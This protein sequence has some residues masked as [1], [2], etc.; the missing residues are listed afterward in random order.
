ME[1][2]EQVNRRKVEKDDNELPAALNKQIVLNT[3]FVRDDFWR[4]IGYNSRCGDDGFPVPGELIKETRL[5]MQSSQK[6]LASLIGCDRSMVAKME[7][8]NHGLDSLTPRRQ[9]AKALGI[10]PLAFGLVERKDVEKQ[11][12][13]DPS[14]LRKAL[15]L[16][17]EVYFS[18]G[19]VGG[20]AEVD[21]MTAK[22]Y[23]ISKG[24]DHKNRDI[25]E[26]LCQYYQLGIDLA[27]EELKYKAADRYAKNALAIGKAL[28]D[29]SLLASTT[30]RYI[31]ALYEKGAVDHSME[32]VD[33]ALSYVKYVSPVLA[34]G[35]YN[36]VANPLS[37]KGDSRATKVLEKSYTILR[38]GP[39]E[40]DA[41]YIRPTMA[42]IH[43]RYAAVHNNMG[44]HEE[45]LDILDL[46]EENQ[47][48]Q[49]RQCIIRKQQA[50]AFFGLGEYRQ[51]AVT[52]QT[53]LDIA[54]EINSKG[55]SKD[56]E[57]IYTQLLASPVKDTLEVKRLGM[58][59]QQM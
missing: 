41:G 17:R 11:I 5:K 1:S 31:S 40:E 6:D 30:L 19:D 24:L 16:D 22:I 14:L 59:F 32:Y 18:G 25:L 23:T 9:L 55:N 7:K 29:K 52:A 26:I 3:R 44:E 27:R 56:I 12:L 10:S 37:A 53:A 54:L 15:K 38:S 51:A 49:R 47:K 42:Y 48:Y 57:A 35:I 28:N 13:Y 4:S 36:S 50:K 33:E 46:A 43:M 20:T 21:D 8:N 39:K 58:S 2:S 45:A 34:I